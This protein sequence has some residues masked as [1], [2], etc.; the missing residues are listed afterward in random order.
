[1]K[2]GNVEVVV[3][4]KQDAFLHIEECMEK[5]KW[6][7]VD[8]LK[9]PDRKTKKRDFR[10]MLVGRRDHSHDPRSGRQSQ[11]VPDPYN[12]SVTDLVL[13]RKHRAMFKDLEDIA[14]N[15]YRYMIW[16]MNSNR[17]VKI[18]NLIAFR[19]KGKEFIVEENITVFQEWI[20]NQ[21]QEEE[22]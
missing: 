22:Q 11:Y 5:A 2:R 18:D 6:I 12:I 19:S 8:I 14:P 16:K 21:Q 4:K 15:L 9:Q 7:S 1:M 17:I 3:V 13:L 10:R 20:A